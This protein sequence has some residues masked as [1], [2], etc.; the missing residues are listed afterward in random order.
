MGK[1]PTIKSSGMAA[2][3]KGPFDFMPSPIHSPV[4]A[5]EPQ[6]KNLPPG[7]QQEVQRRV[8]KLDEAYEKLTRL[9]ASM[10]SK[11]EVRVSLQPLGVVIDINAVVLFQSAKAELTSGALQLIEQVA[12][13]LR[14]L[15]YRIQVNGYTDNAQIHSAQFKSNWDL[16]AARAISVVKR[17]V[18]D[19]IDP[20]LLVGAGY[21]EYHP[22]ASND[23]LEGMGMN[24]RVSIVVVSPVEGADPSQT[25]LLGEPQERSGGARAAGAETRQI[26]GPPQ[27]EAQQKS[28]RCDNPSTDGGLC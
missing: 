14:D 23:T 9:L 15:N 25:P 1:I 26:A 17:F 16:S 2:A 8:E 20:R 10:I 13:V 5:R 22:V 21:G 11:G 18:M 7:L 12:S 24:R 27:F 6:V 3:D 19:G 28:G 4:I